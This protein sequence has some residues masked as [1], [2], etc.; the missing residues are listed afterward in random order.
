MMKQD[1]SVESPEFFANVSPSWKGLVWSAAVPLGWLVLF[2]G[3]VGHIWV[4]LGGW[5]RFGETHAGALHVHER[6]VWLLIPPLLFSW[7]AA[8]ML[9]FVCLLFRRWRH[10]SVYTLTYAVTLTFAALAALLAPQPFLNWF[11]D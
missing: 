10:F 4:A 9:F 7:Y 1:A 5:P 8:A 2:Y 11:M 6:A 3:L